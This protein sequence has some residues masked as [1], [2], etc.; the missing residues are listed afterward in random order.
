MTYIYCLVFIDVFLFYLLSQSAL[1]PFKLISSWRVPLRRFVPVSVISILTLFPV[2]IFSFLTFCPRQP[3]FCPSH[4]FLN[5][6]LLMS[7]SASIISMFCLSTFFYCWG[8]YFDVLLMNGGCICIDGQVFVCKRITSVCFF[9]KRTI[10]KLPFAR[11]ANGKRIKENRL[12]FRS[13]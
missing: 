11:W 7:H 13:L 4:Y 12:G 3:N 5:S 1:F 2:N 8:I 10:N 9:I 6:I